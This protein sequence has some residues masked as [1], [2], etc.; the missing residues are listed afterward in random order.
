MGLRATGYLAHYLDYAAIDEAPEMWHLW[1][2]YGSLSATLGRRCWLMHTGRPLYANIYV[3]FVGNAAAGKNSALGPCRRL[4]QGLEDIPLSY[5]VE[6]VEG[7][8]R[9]IGGRPNADP[10]KPS[11][12]LRIRKDH[13]GAMVETHEMCFMANEFVDLIRIAP[14]AWTV[15][16]NN[17]FDCQTYDYGTKNSGED[18]L[19]NPYIT[20]I[21]GLT[22]GQAQ[23]LH[24]VDII[25]SGFARRALLQHGRRAFENPIPQPFFGPD[26]HRAMEACAARLRQI[27]NL[28]GEIKLTPDAEVWWNEWYRH[29]NL[30][31]IP[32]ATPATEGYF[33]S[34]SMQLQKLAILTS[35]A[36]R[37][38]LLITPDEFESAASYLTEMEKSFT[39]IFGAMGRNENAQVAMT[40][41]EH[42]RQSPVPV[43]FTKL[44]AQYY[45]QFTSGRSGPE[46]IEVMSYLV[47]LGELRSHMS[48]NPPVMCWATADVMERFLK[49]PVIP[50]TPPAAS[51][52]PTSPATHS[53]SSQDAPSATRPT[54]SP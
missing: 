47:S 29:N 9:K 45:N 51:S 26:Q 18:I 53:A 40:I 13:T 48:G 17:I 49:A 5:A 35:V 19:T 52:A 31:V 37:D 43:S 8:C 44:F 39:F 25:N 6:T 3:L 12:C 41:L 24:K 50:A 11:T 15:F 30:E 23:K 36:N 27:R 22:T 2:A 20:I 42:I 28:A 32:K 38:D 14:E 10:P 46:L 1:A 54:A 33:G 16:L 34:R 4:L 7:V 21:A